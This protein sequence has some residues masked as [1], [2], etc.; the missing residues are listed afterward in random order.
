MLSRI[1]RSCGI[2]TLIEEIHKMVKSVLIFIVF[3]LIV[4]PASAVDET[5]PELDVVPGS[6]GDYSNFYYVE[7][8]GGFLP[9]P[10]DYVLYYSPRSKNAV[11]YKELKRDRRGMITGIEMSMEGIRL[12]SLLDCE[13]PCLDYTSDKDNYEIKRYRWI[14]NLNATVFRDREGYEIVYIYNEEVLVSFGNIKEKD[15]RFMLAGFTKKE[16]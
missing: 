10:N 6:L 7:V 13:K 9:I 11:F 5:L 8:F 14:N 12:T 4:I 3:S 16:E 2:I 1:G 15:W